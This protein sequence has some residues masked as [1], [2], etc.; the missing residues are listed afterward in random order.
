M[1]PYDPAK[2]RALLKEAGAENL[3]LTLRLPPPTYA[4]RGGE[5]IAGMLSEVGITAKIENVEWPI[6]IGQVYKEKQFDLTVISHVEPMDMNNYAKADYYWQYDSADF[7][8]IYGK[9]ERSTTPE[10]QTK[11]LQAAQRKIAEDAVNAFLFEGAKLGVAQKGLNGM[12]A[13]W[14]SFINEVAALSWEG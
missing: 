10:D 8:E 4:R 5:V 1:Y 7:R 3:E 6:W 2:A 12:W 13:S 9:F 14:P 11:W